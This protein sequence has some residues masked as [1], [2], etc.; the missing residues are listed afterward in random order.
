MARPPILEDWKQDP[1][2]DP[3]ELYDFE[4]EKLR[5]N[6]SI[7][8]F[9]G[10]FAALLLAA[11]LLVAGGVA[12]W[13]VRQVNPSGKAG[14]KINFTVEANDDLQA[15][16]DRMET[17]GIVSS[18]KVFRWYVKQKGGLTLQPGYYTVRPKDNMGNILKALKTSPAATFDKVTF[19]EG[20]TVDQIGARL[21]KTVTRMSTATFA[22]E[23]AAGQVRSQFQPPEVSSLEGMLFPDTYQ[24][25]GNEDERKVLEKLVKQMERIAL[26]ENIDKLAPTVGVWPGHP[27]GMTP[28]EVLTVASIIEREG[29]FQDD[30]EKIA[31]VIYNRLALEKAFGMKLEVDATLSYGQPPDTPF[32]VLRATDSPYNTY[33]YGGLPPTPIASP[34]RASIFAALHPAPSPPLSECVAVKNGV[35]CGYLFYVLKDKEGHHA[36]ATNI[37]DH[38]KN[39]KAAKEAGLLG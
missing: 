15:L 34:G 19:P 36:F 33:K 23:A 27:Q 14:E 38:N 16:S 18:A 29:K 4:T 9:V 2:D 30:R 24:V 1:W 35:G 22:A 39:V 20:F 11:G 8:R 21:S 10:F 12:V 26:S 32:S 13:T 5:P 37:A 6:R 7:P 17:G 28:Y 25:G 31:Q 3:D